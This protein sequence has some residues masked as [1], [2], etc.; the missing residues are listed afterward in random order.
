MIELER[1]KK[2][3]MK[4]GCHLPLTCQT[5]ER[6]LSKN[7]SERGNAGAVKGA[8]CWTKLRLY[9]IV[10]LGDYVNIIVRHIKLFK[11]VHF[12]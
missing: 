4:W 3:Q 11:I 9:L 10:L 8:V 6:E 12:L 1:K 7:F 2:R 5:D